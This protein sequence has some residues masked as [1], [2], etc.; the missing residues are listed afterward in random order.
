[1]PGCSWAAN[2]MLSFSRGSI[3][4][5]NATDVVI[6]ASANSYPEYRQPRAG[7]TVGY[8]NGDQRHKVR[9]WG[10]YDLPDARRR[11]ADSP[12]DSCSDTTRAPATTSAC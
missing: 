10:T 11:W 6:R 8:L 3:E 2:Y 5:E 7:T 12:S 9:V 1:M 4:A